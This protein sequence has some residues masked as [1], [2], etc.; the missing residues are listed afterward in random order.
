MFIGRV[1]RD[2]LRLVDVLHYFCA[3]RDSFY[4]YLHSGEHWKCNIQFHFFFYFFQTYR[5][6]WLTLVISNCTSLYINSPLYVII[7]LPIRVIALQTCSQI[8]CSI[9]SIS[10]SMSTAAGEGLPAFLRF[11]FHCKTHWIDCTLTIELLYYLYT[12]R[13]IAFARSVRHFFKTALK[14]TSSNR[15]ALFWW[16]RQQ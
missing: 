5:K 1:L 3:W 14:K 7:F 13:Y 9:V 4:M 2:F 10:S 12:S 11:V 16:N 15:I 8:Y 6:M